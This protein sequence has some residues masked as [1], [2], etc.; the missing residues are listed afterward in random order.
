MKKMKIFAVALVCF[1]MQSLTCL[2]GNDLISVNELPAPAVQF[3]ADHFGNHDITTIE[4]GKQGLKTTYTVTLNDGTSISFQKNGKWKSVKSIENAVPETLVPTTITNYV[5][6]N[7][8]GQSIVKITND[9]MGYDVE[10]SNRVDLSFSQNPQLF[11][12]N[13]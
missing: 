2:A 12:M 13:F 10:L 5:S 1:T 11:G 6:K 4:K 8:P 7:H 9:M 3:V